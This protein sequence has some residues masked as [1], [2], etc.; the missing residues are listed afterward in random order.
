LKA[1][2]FS[3]TLKNA[4]AYYNA[5]FVVVNSEV[6]GLA[7]AKV[8]L[9]IIAEKY[10]TQFLLLPSCCLIPAHGPIGPFILFQEN[11]ASK[12]L[13]RGKKI[14]CSY[15]D[16]CKDPEPQWLPLALCGWTG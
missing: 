16:A 10:H 12:K 5:G 11:Q 1:K 15:P 6:V 9:S 14:I 2:I 13:A 8:S 3:S 7:P 4:L